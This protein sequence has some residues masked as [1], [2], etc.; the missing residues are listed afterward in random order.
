MENQNLLREN[1]ERRL[2]AVER[3]QKKQRNDK[4]VNTAVGSVAPIIAGG[5][6]YKF[7]G[8]QARNAGKFVGEAVDAINVTRRLLTPNSRTAEV[9][10]YMQR[11]D[12]NV[13]KQYLANRDEKQLRKL[14]EDAYKLLRDTAGRASENFPGANTKPVKGIRNLK[15]KIIEATK[16]WGDKEETQTRNT[17][18]YQT[19]YNH[20]AAIRFSA[21]SRL[22][23]IN[24][25]IEEYCA[26]LAL[27]ETR[28]IKIQDREI[29]TLEKMAKEYN[30]ISE[31]AEGSVELSVQEVNNGMRSEQ[32]QAIVGEAK[33]YG[34][35]AA[36]YSA[37]GTGGLILGT[38]LAAYAGHVIAKP[39]T[40][41]AKAT[42][43]GIRRGA[44]AISK[45]KSEKSK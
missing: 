9:K 21:I 42:V 23:Q 45:L 39:A 14:G 28:G 4:R 16:F 1:L 13:A 11:A 34:L 27:N 18:Q 35:K 2:R 3:W 25:Q 6:F 20:L 33:N 31:I 26:K 43:N 36:D 32:Y 44:K 22:R 10:N 19:N 12:P 41:V 30:A 15:G 40:A 7:F 29:K 17:Q 37:Y 38:A 24:S 8:N 5:A